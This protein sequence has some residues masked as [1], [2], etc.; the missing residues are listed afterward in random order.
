MLGFNYE[1][2]PINKNIPKASFETLGLLL[3]LQDCFGNT[4]G[5]RWLSSLKAWFHHGIKK[6]SFS[7]MITSYPSGYCCTAEPRFMW[8]FTI[9]H[10][11]NHIIFKLV[12]AKHTL[13]LH[14]MVCR[15]SAECYIDLMENVGWLLLC[16]W[17]NLSPCDVYGSGCVCRG[18]EDGCNDGVKRRKA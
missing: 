10:A 4:T 14:R 13:Y 17:I 18:E 12:A 16:H 6:V 7:W 5:F 11:C 2:Y 3:L 8:P 9:R 1:E 15:M